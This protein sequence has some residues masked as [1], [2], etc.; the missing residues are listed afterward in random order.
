LHRKLENY[1]SI[2]V[3]KLNFSFALSYE[4][5]HFKNTRKYENEKDIILY[6][7]SKMR[8]SHKME[9]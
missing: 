7:K 1:F 9:R 4:Q 6:I 5:E 2:C 3:S 8:S